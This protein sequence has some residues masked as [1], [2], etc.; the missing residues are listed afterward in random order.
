MSSEDRRETGTEITPE[1]LKCGSPLCDIAPP[2]ALLHSSGQATEICAA[3]QVTL[4]PCPCGGTEF[5][6]HSV[7]QCDSQ[8][9]QGFAVL[10]CIHSLLF[11]RKRDWEH[12]SLTG[13]NNGSMLSLCILTKQSSPSWI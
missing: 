6:W 8:D 13:L 5:L 10:F 9:H 4:Q 1:G 2:T 11:C 7:R 12:E 3:E